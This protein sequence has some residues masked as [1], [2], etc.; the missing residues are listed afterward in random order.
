MTAPDDGAP[1]GV[2]VRALYLSL[3]A[4][5]VPAGV[6]LLVP[7][8]LGEHGALLW[9]S[10]LIP[11]FLLAYYKGW[12]GAAMALAAGMATL[13]VTQVIALLLGQTLPSGLFSV[14][15]AY[16]VI[17][18]GIGWLAEV[19]L[20]DKNRMEGMAFEDALTHLPNR[21]HARVFLENEFAAAQRGRLLCVVL[22]DLDDFKGYNDR[23][24]HPAGDEALK[25]FADILANTTRRMNLSARFGGEEFLSILAGSDLD[26][27]VAFAERVRATFGAQELGSGPLTVC[28][29]VALHHPSMGTPDELLATADHA[30]YRAKREGRNTVRL[31]GT[32]LL[33]PVSGQVPMLEEERVETADSGEYPRAP[34]E[35]GKSRPTVMLL[36]QQTTVFGSGR[37][38]LLVEDEDPVR[39]LISTYLKR[40]GFSVTEVTDVTSA[41][42][43]L[44][45]E[46]D[47]IVTS[48]LLTEG[49]SSQLVTAIKSRWPATQVVVMTTSSEVHAA[50][51]ALAAGADRHMVKP[52]GMPE[53]RVGI[54]DCLARRDRVVADRAARRSAA[55]DE[56]KYDVRGHVEEATLALVRA[57]EAKDPSTVGHGEMVGAMALE[58]AK[59]LDSEGAMLDPQAVRLG[60]LIHDIGKI[61]L[62]EALL[63]KEGPLDEGE[64]ADMRTHPTVGRQLLAP[65]LRDA[66]VDAAVAW[67]HERWD[68]GGYPDGL[69]GD[70]I[71]LAARITAIADALAAMTSP[72]AFRDAFSF[73]AAVE[74]VRASFGTRYDPGLKEVFEAALPGLRKV[75]AGSDSPNGD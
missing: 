46:F 64:W 60:G 37:K 50:A 66:T 4:L 1:K 68:G 72:R 57:E 8:I 61:S 53:L 59:A 22:F 2:P 28:A 23:Y 44:G 10:A 17:I 75:K 14:V 69:A 15:V 9:L 47:V 7:D 35:I 55:T 40:E 70:A 19:L 38:V 74:E 3:G 6:G 33:D 20:R 29:G 12:R 26:G 21:R 31:S 36:P 25:V 52:F 18:L 54:V 48:Q 41:L 67:H 63:N 73:D 49:S 5:V 24:G 13:A 43:N 58:L 45:T 34:E 11:A 71:P 56:G 65:L 51:A 32:A 42:R 39:A 27:A 16:I 30:L 62:S